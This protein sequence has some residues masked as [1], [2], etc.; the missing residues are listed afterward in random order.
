[1][2]FHFSLNGVLRL[3]ESLEKAELQQLRAIAAAVASSR[4][5]LDSLD[6]NIETARRW[7]LDATATRGL[8]GAELHFEVLRESVL[9]TVRSSLAEKLAALERKRDEQQQ[10]YLQAR[11]Q[12][13][14]LS[15][16]YQRQLAAYR[17]E[18]SRR[19][20]Q[21][22]DELFLIRSNYTPE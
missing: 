11:R 13:E 4:A 12:R 10:R 18:Q 5:D 3:R 21:R 7:T 2:A 22:I 8:T 17:L 14:I 6:K 9:Q 16:L 15:N 20:Q 19:E 1:M